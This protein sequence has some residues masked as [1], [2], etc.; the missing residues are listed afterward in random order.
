MLYSIDV[1]YSRSREGKVRGKLCESFGLVIIE[2]RFGR[3]V[4]SKTY[5]ERSKYLSR[6]HQLVHCIDNAHGRSQAL[7]SALFKLCFVGT[8]SCTL[9]APV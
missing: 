5:P 8:R 3:R 7:S 1:E 4:L 9:R 6:L 2:P